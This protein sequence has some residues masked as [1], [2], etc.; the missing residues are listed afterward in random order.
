MLRVYQKS[1]SNEKVINYYYINKWTLKIQKLLLMNSKV[2]SVHS[3]LNHNYGFICLKNENH[4]L[5][6]V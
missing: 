2:I 1:V 3:R 6:S 5:W 4:I